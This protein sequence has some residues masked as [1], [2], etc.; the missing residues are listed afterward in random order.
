MKWPP[1]DREGPERSQEGGKDEKVQRNLSC[2][3]LGFP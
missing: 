2:A 1:P 3:L